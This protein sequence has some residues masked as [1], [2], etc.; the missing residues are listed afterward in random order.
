MK[1]LDAKNKIFWQ[2]DSFVNVAIFFLFAF[3]YG[4]C[5]CLE[6]A[7]TGKCT[8]TRAFKELFANNIDINLNNILLHL[9]AV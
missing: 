7:Y 8:C 6:K 9:N 2:N 5:L 4:F 1:K 3:K